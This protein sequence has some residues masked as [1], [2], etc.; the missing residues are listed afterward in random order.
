LHCQAHR[1]R[2]FRAVRIK[3]VHTADANITSQSILTKFPNTFLGNFL[4]KLPQIISPSPHPAGPSDACMFGF[5]AEEFSHFIFVL[6][7]TMI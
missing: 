5:L 2:A 6:K 7:I 3:A 4:A 1:E